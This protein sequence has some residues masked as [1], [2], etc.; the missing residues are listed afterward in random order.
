[1]TS[2]QF[3]PSV[4]R[5]VGQWA[6]TI[7]PSSDLFRATLYVN[8]TRR[9]SPRFAATLAKA[10]ALWRTLIERGQRLDCVR[11]DIPNDHL[12]RLIEANDLVL[13]AI[14]LAR[15]ARLTRSAVET[16]MRLV[17]DTFKRL[18]VAEP[19]SSWPQPT[20]TKRRRR[21]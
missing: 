2:E 17:I 15:S 10:H 21:G 6:A 4:E 7:D 3:W 9:R 1:M 20:T 19:P 16:H 12:V 8:E 14:F 18:L 13:D 5:F 11:T